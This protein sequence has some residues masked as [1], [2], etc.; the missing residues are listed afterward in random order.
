MNNFL[1]SGAVLPFGLLG[2][3]PN[4]AMGGFNKTYRNFPLRVGII[5]SIYPITSDSNHSKLST[6]YDVL[7]IEQHENKGSTP[8]LYRN[9]L[10]SEGLGSVADFF[11]KNLRV[12]EKQEDP[13][14]FPGLKGQNGAVVLMLCLDAMS[15][16]GIIISCLTNPDRSTTLKNDMPHLE[17]EYNGVHIVVNEDGSTSLTFKGATDNDGDVIDSTQGNTVL[18]IAKDGS[19][20]VQHSTI[21]QT[22]ARSGQATL[23]ATDNIANNTQKDFDVS[24]GGN[25]NL[26][27]TKDLIAQMVNLTT[28]ASGTAQ[29]QCQKMQVQSASEID[30]QGAQ[31]SIEAES[32]ANIKAPS[33]ILTGEVA[34]GGQGGTPVL[35]MTS[36]IVGIGN[37]SMPVL[38]MGITGASMVTAQ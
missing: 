23:T 18:S 9:C 35:T 31:I 10:S 33:I 3:N 24:A 21:T 28:T 6:E 13:L 14:D 30:L 37:L 19:Y 11:E 22:L 17:G 1:D 34:L 38:S 4:A 20:Q 25:I 29:L 12:K 2:V 8:I 32:M 27:A 5:V 36:L 26:T 7:V 16:K 15:E